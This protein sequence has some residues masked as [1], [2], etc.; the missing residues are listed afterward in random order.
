[1]L[2]RDSERILV[3]ALVP[4]EHR[5]LFQTS[6]EFHAAIVAITQGLPHIV[7]GLAIH[8]AGTVAQR[9]AELERHLRG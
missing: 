1:M 3:A 4:T 2:D 5:H 8:C 6:A 7:E 9:R